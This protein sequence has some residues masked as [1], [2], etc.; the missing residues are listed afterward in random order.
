[1]KGKWRE[2]SRS[3]IE[4]SGRTMSDMTASASSGTSETKLDVDPY[5]LM[6]DK[7][8]KEGC[9]AFVK[10]RSIESGSRSTEQLTDK[11]M[12][13]QGRDSSNAADEDHPSVVTD[14]FSKLGNPPF[15]NSLTSLAGIVRDP[16]V[17]REDKRSRCSTTVF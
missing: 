6:T 11:D 10:P 15:W 4:N 3:L 9:E 8:P 5:S 1:M 13:A 2:T 14:N 17:V 12:N 16:R 7:D